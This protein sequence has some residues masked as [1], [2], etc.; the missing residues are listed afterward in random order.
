MNKQLIAVARTILSLLPLAAIAEPNFELWESPV[1]S[2]E[3]YNNWDVTYEGDLAD[4]VSAQNEE[5][6]DTMKVWSIISSEYMDL[7]TTKFTAGTCTD[8]IAARKSDL[9]IDPVSGN[10]L[11]RG[12]AKDRLVQAQKIGIPIG[13]DPKVWAIAVFEPGKWALAL[14]HVAYVEYVWDNGVMIISDMNFKGK[15]VVTQRVISTQLPLGYI[16]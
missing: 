11:I 6:V 5:I 7:N 15:N 16:Y 4:I 9:F 8:Y 1:I 3:V 13:K 2:P 14:G 12:N 10:R